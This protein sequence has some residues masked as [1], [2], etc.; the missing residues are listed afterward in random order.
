MLRRGKTDHVGCRLARW[1]AYTRADTPKHSKIVQRGNRCCGVVSRSGT[2][3][4]ALTLTT[5]DNK[6][7]KA[8]RSALS[9]IPGTTCILDG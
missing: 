8:S 9:T 3:S 5:G 6:L 2:E 4:E 7:T 1:N